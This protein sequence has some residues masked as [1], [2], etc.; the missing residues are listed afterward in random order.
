MENQ[1]LSL[2][3]QISL[4]EWRNTPVN[5]KHLLIS[6][7]TNAVRSESESYLVRLLDEI[8]IGI[9]VCNATEQIVYLNRSGRLLLESDRP[10]KFAPEQF[11]TAFQVYCQDTQELYS[12]ALLSTKALAGEQAFADNLEI[13]CGDRQIPIEVLATPIFDSHER[14]TYAIV[15]F[16]KI[17]DRQSKE[18]EQQIQRE[19]ALNRVLQT[20]RNSLDLNTVFAT[21][22]E[23][24]A[25]LLKIL[26]CCVVQYLPQLGVWRHLAEFR[27]DPNTST[28]IG[29]DIPDAGNPFAEQLKDLQIVRIENAS[30]LDDEI[31]QKLAATFPG[32]WLLIPLTIEGTLWGSLTISTT[33][34][35][36]IWHDS[37]VKIAQAVAN[38]LEIAIGQANLYQQAQLEIAERRRVEI[39]LRES[40]AKFQN[41]AANVPGVI[42][43]YVL[44]PDGS[45]AITYISPG[46]YSLWEIE[47]PQILAD[48]TVLWEMV[49]PEDL[50]SLIK[51]IE[52]SGKNLQP[53]SSSWRIITPSGQTKWLQ[54]AGKPTKQANGDIIWD[55]LIQD[56]SERI[57]SE[58]AI[59]RENAFR[60]QILENMSEGLCVHYELKDAP[61]VRFTLWN[62]QMQAITGYTLEEINLLGWFDVLHPDSE[63]RDRAIASYQRMLLEEDLFAG[64]CEIRHKDGQLRTVSIS[65]SFLTNHNGLTHVLLI[66]Q[67]ITERKQA[68]RQLI[69]SENKFRAIFERAAVGIVYASL[70]NQGNPKILACNPRFCEM[71][72]YTAAELSQLTAVDI[73]HPDDR[74]HFDRPKLFSGEIPRFILE[75]RY[76]R[77][78]G[79]VMWANT[80]VTILEG[81]PEQ[82]LK[83]VTVIED[84]S[85]RKQAETD[86][87]ES[88]ARYRLVTENMNDLVCLHEL[89]GSYLYVSP[90]CQTLLGY[91][92]EEMLG[93]DPYSF[94]HPEDGDR[95]YQE[96][97]DAIKGNPQ[98]VTYRM[99]HKT[100]SYIWFETLTKPIKDD[101][102]QVIRL[103]TTSRDVSERVRAQ[104]QLKHEALHDT[105]T[106]LP[107]RTLLMERLE[108][109]INRVKRSE[110]HSF[111]ILFLDLD[112][113]KIINDSLGHLAGDR[114]LI[115][116]AQ[117]LQTILRA[118][119][120]AARL[121]GD[122]FVVLLEDIEG[123]QEAVNITKRI[124]AKLQTPL[125]LE[126]REVYTTPSI[127]I[128]LGDSSY[129][130]AT[131]LLRDADI[132]MYRAKNKGKARYEIFNTEMH[133]RVLER[134][135]LESDLRKA[136]EKQE[137]ILYYQQL[138]DLNT[139]K[140]IGFEALIRWQH[141]TQGLK[142]P[143]EFITVAEETGLIAAIDSWALQTACRQLAAWQIA[144]PNFS[145]LRV[146]VNLSSPD[147]QT[148]HF[149]ENIDR[150]LQQ[151]DL[152]GQFLN[153]EIT[154]SMLIDNVDC[155]I[156]LL[157]QLQTRG[158]QIS[159][160]DFGTGYSSL[161]YLHRLPINTLKIDRSFVS[162]MKE[163]DKNHQIVKTITAL[164]NQLEIDTIAEGIEIPYQ[165]ETLKNLGCKFGQGYLFSQP[166][167]QAEAEAL[168]ASAS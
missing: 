144:F 92:P 34:Q 15:S 31:N 16:Y 150:I 8:Q 101:S 63:T 126:G 50:Q 125:I 106:G 33:Q 68:E 81:E 67:D 105:L 114:L 129:R 4:E 59:K 41:M 30:K 13:R 88:E 51:S 137:F 40:E 74:E 102:G 80:T 123:I 12:I 142:T 164:S 138:V 116:V 14:V 76:R 112:R 78:D 39:A 10:A 32:A 147:L 93:K 36:H 21:A 79:T 85:E 136:V 71:L 72:G 97:S 98:P 107:N 167:S 121:G 66:I 109:A 161:S 162:A 96:H 91:S 145:N 3:Q 53:W 5:V 135:H 45:D 143:K 118:T 159:I 157:K 24:T 69:A 168:L 113:F 47:T 87:R 6:S 100:G 148:K 122:E 154:E 48:S 1:Q 133:V 99:R 132:A 37:Q 94:F 141:P 155:T 83:T 115:T 60:Q 131:D 29:I 17:S 58:A 11:N 130:Q 23:E 43:R 119:D 44:C 151:T 54:G 139:R 55:T 134:L 120:L 152:D 146:S 65:A 153:L 27:C 64:E 156:T 77:K 61:F 28:A 86:L 82:P 75:K 52:N 140:L 20:I 128:V 9:A 90:S 127:G 117:K 124:F 158:I 26:H 57:F 2:L 73:T 18:L 149:L 104:H 108:L 25:R 56:I 62:R 46:G 22:T 38:Q 35:P 110:Q 84:I 89:K 70:E 111:A 163:G 19:R 49:Y 7:L 165:L 166:L 103:Q 42:L 95:I 160:D